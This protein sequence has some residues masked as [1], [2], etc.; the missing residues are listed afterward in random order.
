MSDEAAQLCT[1]TYRAPELFEPTKNTYIDTRSDVWSLG[2]LLFAWFYGYS[3]FECEF[4][5]NNNI[6]VTE[7]SYSRVL[8]KIPKKINQNKEDMLI[9]NICEWILLKDHIK[10]PYTNDVIF[11]IQNIIDNYSNLKHEDEQFV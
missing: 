5:D 1:I 6:K 10:R 9:M 3:P 8:S 4:L 7:C 2:C 11:R